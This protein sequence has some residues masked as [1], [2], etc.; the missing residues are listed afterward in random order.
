MTFKITVPEYQLY[1]HPQDMMELRKDIWIDE[2]LP[3]VL[4]INK[5][6]LEVDLAYRGSH[7]R[8]FKKKS[9][10]IV[11]YKPKTYRNAKEIHLNAEYKDI[12]HI[13]NKLSLDFFT[14]IGCLA[15]DSRFI[16]LI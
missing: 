15:P 6:K 4:K 7:I 5:K 3:A 11:F 10:H 12:S 2:P 9:Y 8:G 14:D 13:R 1:I 16:F